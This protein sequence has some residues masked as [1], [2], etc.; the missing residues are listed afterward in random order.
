MLSPN[1]RPMPAS[2]RVA[3]FVPRIVIWPP[4]RCATSSRIGSICAVGE[5]RRGE[6]P[7]GRAGGD[8]RLHELDEPLDGERAHLLLRL[9]GELAER[10]PEVE[11]E[12]VLVHVD[13]RDHLLARHLRPLVADDVREDLAALALPVRLH[14]AEVFLHVVGVAEADGLDL[15]HLAGD[16]VGQGVGPREV[17][18]VEGELLEVGRVA[19]E[20]LRELL[21]GVGLQLLAASRVLLGLDPTEGVEDKSV[22]DGGGS[23]LGSGPTRTGLAASAP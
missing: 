17:E 23:S 12:L 8:R 4:E 18:Q 7:E 5:R 10:P 9:G 2:L 14:A 22:H 15:D 1:S 6:R 13:G 3:T 11:R 20:V 21:V 19:Q 16:V